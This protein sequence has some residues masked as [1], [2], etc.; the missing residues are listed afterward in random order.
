[1]PASIQCLIAKKNLMTPIVAV[2]AQWLTARTDPQRIQCAI[3]CLCASARSH[4]EVLA[5]FIAI[6]I[7]LGITIITAIDI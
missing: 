2:G 1:M 3:R 5:V 4:Y 6:I 7:I